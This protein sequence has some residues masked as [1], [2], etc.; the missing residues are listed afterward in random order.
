MALLQ[1]L[2]VRKYRMNEVF[3]TFENYYLSRKRYPRFFANAIGD[4][5]KMFSTGCCYPL[6][7]RDNEG[8]KVVIL[9]A[10]KW[11]PDEFSYLDALRLYCYISM[12]LCEEEETQ[13]AGIVGISDYSH[14]S[15]TNLPSPAD[16]SDF[17]DISKKVATFRQ[18]GNYI[19]NLP[20]FG[21]FLFEIAMSI[22]TE[23]LRSRLHIVRNKSDMKNFINPAI[24]PTEY[25]GICSKQDMMKEFL[26][27]EEKHVKNLRKLSDFKID[28]SKVDV[29]KN[30]SRNDEEK[31]GSFR[32]LE[33]D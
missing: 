33:I 14:V 9:Q 16:L 32:T 11:D 25:G 18:K 6:A 28:F 27:L 3:Q 30:E 19:V 10:G 26:A 8:R 5:M 24:L 13:I 21:R 12:V 29:S 4:S 22:M 17:I 20:S 2:R 23:K 15:A 1:I 7:G 31:I